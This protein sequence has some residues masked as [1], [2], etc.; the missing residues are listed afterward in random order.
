MRNTYFIK[1]MSQLAANY[2]HEVYK[3][4][5]YTTAQPIRLIT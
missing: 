3:G 2:E 5:S 4:A 1:T